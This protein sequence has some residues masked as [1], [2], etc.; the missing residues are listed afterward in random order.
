MKSVT[1]TILFIN[2]LIL[3]IESRKSLRNYIVLNN[4]L[5]KLTRNDYLI[6]DSLNNDLICRLK[7]PNNDILSNRLSNLMLYPSQ[8]IIASIKNTWSSS[9]KLLFSFI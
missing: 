7:S 2:L 1:S 4:N 9:C 3:S 6:Y 8:Q 5:N